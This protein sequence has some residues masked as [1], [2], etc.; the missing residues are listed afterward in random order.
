MYRFTLS[1]AFLH[2]LMLLSPLECAVGQEHSSVAHDV[3]SVISKLKEYY[4]R[5]YTAEI[6]CS[7]KQVQTSLSSSDKAGMVTLDDLLV[8]K[9]NFGRREVLKKTMSSKVPS[10]N[11]SKEV[12]LTANE[13]LQLLN[14]TKG[15]IV[16]VG[17]SRTHSVKAGVPPV[18]SICDQVLPFGFFSNGRKTFHILEWLKNN[19]VKISR[20]TEK[21]CVFES[22][23]S[24]GNLEII[25]TSYDNSFFVTSLTYSVPADQ[26]TQSLY[27]KVEYRVDS[28]KVIDRFWLPT[29]FVVET[30]SHGEGGFRYDPE[31]KTEVPLPP[32]PYS[33]KSQIVFTDVKLNPFPKNQALTFDTMIPDHTQVQLFSQQQIEHVWIKGK[34]VPVTDEV[35]LANARGHG[36]IPGVREPRFWLMALG[37]AMI[38]IALGR[39][40]YRHFTSKE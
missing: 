5:V 21:E 37:T 40:A 12:L 35:A 18:F 30:F 33:V 4:E 10:G 9:L 26:R 17:D 29:H 27:D 7:E 2:T 6:E 1:I 23:G 11:R 34:I 16:V 32:H 39:M 3:R 28:Y 31:T 14:N 13:D 8:L 20:A 22:S 19:S 38:L 25:L 15:E 24:D 36:F